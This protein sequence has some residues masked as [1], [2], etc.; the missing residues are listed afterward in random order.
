MHVLV[1]G[2][3]GFIGKALC[4]ELLKRHHQVSVL[5]RDVRKARELPFGCRVAATL[6]RVEGPVDGIINLAGEN[7]AAHRWT[8]ERRQLFIDSRVQTTRKLIEF[9]TRARQRP[10]VLV[11]GSAIGWYGAR[12]DDTLEENSPGGGLEEYPAQL[13]RAWEAESRRAEKLGLRVCI[14]RTGIVLAGD[15]GPLAKM[16]PAF[17]M[18]LGGRLGD[19]RQWMSWIHRED[20]VAVLIWLLENPTCQGTWNGTAPLPVT[21][22]EFA[23]QLGLALQR[24]ARL[25][26]PGWLLRLLVGGMAELLLTGQKVIPRRLIEAG[27][28]FR[29][30]RLPAALAAI[31]R[32]ER[33]GVGG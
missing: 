17:R 16:L 6:D 21:N 1:T 24:P 4:T 8:A 14:V 32:A 25:P 33:G 29:H 9:I 31:F 22:A 27:F 10:Q 15:G 20:L 5:T 28:R 7:L 13:C 30:P 26:M 11:S 12:G 18:G 3:T 23:Q 2:G 19:G